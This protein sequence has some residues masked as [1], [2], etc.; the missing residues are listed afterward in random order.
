MFI[1]Y[2]LI[3]LLFILSYLPVY[4]F[5]KKFHP[6]FSLRLGVLPVGLK[7]NK[8]IW[9]HAV[10]VGEAMAVKKLV[11]QLRSAYPNKQLVI[12][13]VTPTGNKIAMDM[14][15]KNDFV[16]FLP[17]DFG[18][19]VK[20]VL[21]VLNPSLFIIAETEIWPNLITCLHKKKIPIIIVN[22]RISDAS[23]RGYLSIRFLL[24]NIFKKVTFFCTQTERDAN[25]FSSLGVK[26]EKIK[27]TGNMKFDAT[28][29]NKDMRVTLDLKSKLG[30]Q[31]DV[32]IF[33]AASTHPKE[34]QI[35][36]SAYAR[37]LET[38]PGLCLIIAPRHPERS[39]EV[40]KIISRF[41]FCSRLISCINEPFICATKTVF[42]LD[43]IGQLNNF[44]SIADIVFVGGSLVKKGGHNILEPAI[45]AKPILFGPH[46]FNFKDIAELFLSNEAAVLVNNAEEMQNS[47]L[48][49]LNH[50]LMGLEF[51][52]CA[53]Q[54]LEKNKGAVTRNLEVIKNFIV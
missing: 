4:L 45:F 33:V 49:F 25:R 10:S 51:G 31:A 52:K 37:L 43:V 14:A 41:Q 48:N 24:R 38:F 8:P 15:G 16:T 1:I 28:P 27:V 40:S 34:E 26:R 36:L 50:P 18:F 47:I 39:K 42:V 54:L 35:I 3:F 5:K 30:L 11:E 46:M 20:K 2:D 6:G 9:I 53:Q 12:S 29:T 13:T 7:L 32:K 19:I 23:F 44:Y 21:D 22:G 17:L